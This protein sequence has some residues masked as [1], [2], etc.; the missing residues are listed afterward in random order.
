VIANEDFAETLGSYA[1]ELLFPPGSAPRLADRLHRVLSL[2]T[3][4]RET[5]GAYLRTQVQKMHSLDA[6]AGKIIA[7]A[8]NT[9]GP[10][11]SQPGVP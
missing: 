1:A 7:V 8:A 5:M 3:R 9:D 4:E 2:G 10:Q 6:L 11:H